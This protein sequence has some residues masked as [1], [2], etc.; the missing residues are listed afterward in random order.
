MKIGENEVFLSPCVA[1]GDTMIKLQ[2]QPMKIQEERDDI[3]ER[4]KKAQGALMRF[5]FHCENERRRNENEWF[6]MT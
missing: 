4:R 1:L 6:K 5:F 2:K 3:E